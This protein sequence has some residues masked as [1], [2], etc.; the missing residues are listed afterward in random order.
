MKIL[1]EKFYPNNPKWGEPNCSYLGSLIKDG[2]EY[3][4][5]L[6]ESSVN[7]DKSWF[8][9]Q[10]E[11]AGDYQSGPILL[12]NKFYISLLKNKYN[13]GSSLPVIETVRQ[14]QLLG[15][16]K[17]TVL[18][19][20]NFTKEYV[21]HTDIVNFLVYPYRTKGITLYLNKNLTKLE[22]VSIIQSP[23]SRWRNTF[24][25]KGKYICS[26]TVKVI[27]S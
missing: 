1:L 15:F 18:K 2:R 7:N 26:S 23:I 6:W 22:N 10:S 13:R 16:F 11:K 4:L 24:F 12:D 25:H 5:G 20:F 8:F 3:D 21:I 27:V 9:V 14:A 19:N 17:S